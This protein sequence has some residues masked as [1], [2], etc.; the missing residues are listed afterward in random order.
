M[1][2]WR[3]AFLDCGEGD[4]CA[5]ARLKPLTGAGPMKSDA[6]NFAEVEEYNIRLGREADVAGDLVLHTPPTMWGD[7]IGLASVVAHE[8]GHDLDALGPRRTNDGDHPGPKAAEILA[9]AVLR[10]HVMAVPQLVPVDFECASSANGGSSATSSMAHASLA[11]GT[12]YPARSR[13]R[14]RRS[15]ARQ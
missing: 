3:A 11:R 5:L 10:L 7:L 1:R 9:L 13:S 8:A 4:S 2:Y 14:P 12:A 6:S 15:L